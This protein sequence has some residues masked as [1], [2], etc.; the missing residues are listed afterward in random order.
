MSLL[1]TVMV[2]H[3]SWMYDTDEYYSNDY[4]WLNIIIVMI[5]IFFFIISIIII[6]IITIIRIFVI[7]FLTWFE[8]IDQLKWIFS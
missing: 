6:N 8:Y 2:F 3:V 7:Y 5:L 4:E 1:A